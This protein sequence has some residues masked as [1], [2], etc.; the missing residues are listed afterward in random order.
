MRLE[1]WVKQIM[2]GPVDHQDHNGSR[3]REQRGQ[4]L[5][6]QDSLE[7]FDVVQASMTWA[8][9]KQIDSRAISEV[10]QIGLPDYEK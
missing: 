7:D 8:G 10:V 9:E 3:I 6:Y 2:E 1:A 5:T 4:W